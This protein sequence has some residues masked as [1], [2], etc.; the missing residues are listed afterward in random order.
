MHRIRSWGP[1]IMSDTTGN[2]RVA[3]VLLNISSELVTLENIVADLEGLFGELLDPNKSHDIKVATRKVQGLD[4]LSQSLL[5]IST[6]IEK[7]AEEIPIEQSFDVLAA[8]SSVT[9]QDLVIRLLEYKNKIDSKKPKQPKD[10][11]CLF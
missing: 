5:N 8:K 10:G 3:S 1:V 2:N 7:L 11:Y 9:Q 6:F 4:Y